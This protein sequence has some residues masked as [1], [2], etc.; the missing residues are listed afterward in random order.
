MLGESPQPELNRTPSLTDNANSFVLIGMPAWDI[1]KPFHSLAVVAGIAREAGIPVRVYDVNIDFYRQ[2]SPEKRKYWEDDFSHLWSAEELPQQ[3]WTE[4]EPWIIAYLDEMLQHGDPLLWAFSVNMT[5]R[6]FSREAARYIKKRRPN[7]PILFGGVD[8]F[9]KEYN[10]RFL[11]PSGDRYCDIICQGEAEIALKQYLQGLVATRDWRTDC[12][13]FAYYRQGTLIDTGEPELPTL[14]GPQPIPA[15]DLF[16][17][18][19]YSDRGS[20]PFFLTRGCIYSCHFC[21]EKPNFKRFRARAAA[22]AFRELQAILPYAQTYKETPTLS[23]SDSNLN[24]N[25]KLL[26]EFA[27]LILTSGVK[28]RWGGQAHIHRRMTSEF[29]EKLAAAGF[30][31]VFWGIESGSQHV[32][33]LMNKC[34]RKEDAR[35]IL[36]DCS[37]A[38]IHQAIPIIV[39]FP[40]ETPEDVAETIQF[41]FEFQDLPDCCVLMPRLVVVRPNSPLYNNYANFGL[42]NN[43]YYEWFTSDGSNTLPIRIVRRFVAQQAQANLTLS[44]K[45]LVDT[46]EI[47]QVRIDEPNTASE[48]YRLLHDICRRGDSLPLF[49]EALDQWAAKPTPSKI[50]GLASAVFQHGKNLMHSIR[51]ARSGTSESLPTNRSVLDDEAAQ[52][53]AHYLTVWSRLDKDSPEGRRGL[54]RLVLASLRTLKKK[55]AV[56]HYDPRKNRLHNAF[57]RVFEIGKAASVYLT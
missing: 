52:E 7:L 11:Q 4:Y 57:R 8:C 3:L 24:A 41:I 36:C 28:V 42:A 47:L 26:E 15:Y 10:Q 50:R 2:V 32:V 45:N 18:S 12:P 44:E 21:S 39:G 25:M 14:Q 35:R 5:T 27:E 22:E 46:Q 43:A 17:L 48:L 9:T 31:S 23:F 56:P 54:Y 38:G 49:Y 30:A 6:L 37:R 20:L 13:G 33:D 53:K 34:Y 19:K 1:S 51:G 55:A 40:G 16:D 29:I